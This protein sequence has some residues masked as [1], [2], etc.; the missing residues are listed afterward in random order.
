MKTIRE[1]EQYLLRFSDLRKKGVQIGG[2]QRPSVTIPLDDDDPHLKEAA[3]VGASLPTPTTSQLEVLA[4]GDGSPL[5]DADTPRLMTYAQWLDLSLPTVPAF[6]RHVRA[7]KEHL[8]NLTRIMVAMEL[9]LTR[10]RGTP[11]KRMGHIV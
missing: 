7:L 5:E 11:Y 8:D 9:D 1:T 4:A 10:Q 6:E 3:A 2:A